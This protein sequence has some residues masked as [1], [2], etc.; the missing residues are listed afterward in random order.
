MAHQRNRSDAHASREL[1]TGS[2]F[3]LGA[4][5]PKILW[6]PALLRV[7]RITLDDARAIVASAGDTLRGVLPSQYNDVIYALL[8][9]PEAPHDNRVKLGPG[10]RAVIGSAQGHFYR[11]RPPLEECAARMFW[12]LVEV[13]SEE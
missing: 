7:S 8:G 12:S 4:V 11:Q 10:D 5:H 1:A 6:Q 13:G 2:T 9:I 3:V